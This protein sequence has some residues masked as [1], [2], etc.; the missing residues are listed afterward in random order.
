MP[1][2]TMHKDLFAG[3]IEL[4]AGMRYQSNLISG[5]EGQELVQDLPMLPFK[6]FEFHGFLGKRRVVSFG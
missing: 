3:A 2:S 1:V 5:D 6:E 4:P